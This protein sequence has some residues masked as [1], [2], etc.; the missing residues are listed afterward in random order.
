MPSTTHAP[1]MASTFGDVRLPM[2]CAGIAAL[3]FTVSM[4]PFSAGLLAAEPELSE[5]QR[6]AAVSAE[7]KRFVEKCDIATTANKSVHYQRQLEPILRWSNPTAGSVYGDIFLYT[8]LGRPAA[9]VSY[10][11]WFNPDWGSTV[12]VH[13][14]SPEL[15]AGVADGVRFWSPKAPGLMY[16]G[17][18]NAGTPAPLPAARLTQLKRL[19]N[20][21]AVQLEDT[22]G[23]SN[24]VKRSLRRLAQPI[25]RFPKPTEE[26]DYIDG[27][28]FAFVEGT[29][30][31]LLLFLDAVQGKTAAVWRFGIARMNRD[32]I[33]VTH[34]D[35]V[36]WEG[37]YLSDPYERPH[38]VYTTFSAKGRMKP[39][40]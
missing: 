9:M 17:L 2:H 8:H 25:Y 4:G 16:A 39:A 22:R 34:N 35:K 32:F 11:K 38:E 23:D 15:I 27:A 30:P 26:S 36:V 7:A 29:D 20:E 40:P 14:F 3:L 6:I 28:V 37:A 12:E 21:F 18:D 33:R 31:E 10:Y 1:R 5:E 24:G 19:A 13:S